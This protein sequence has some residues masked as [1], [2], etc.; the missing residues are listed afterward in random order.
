MGFLYQT[1]LRITQIPFTSCWRWARNVRTFT[2]PPAFREKCAITIHYL[3]QQLFPV[4]C[5][6]IFCYFYGPRSSIMRYVFPHFSTCSTS[7]TFYC[8]SFLNM[9]YVIFLYIALWYVLKYFDLTA[10]KNSGSNLLDIWKKRNWSLTTDP[11]TYYL[12]GI[13]D[14]NKQIKPSLFL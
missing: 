11:N 3:R 4:Q 8:S 13:T 14:L 12:F 6:S 5:S 1:R 7:S 9:Y 2:P 10:I